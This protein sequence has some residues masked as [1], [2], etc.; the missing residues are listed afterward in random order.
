MK[1]LFV[2]LTI[3]V[4]LAGIFSICKPNHVSAYDSIFIY[5]AS[6]LCLRGTTCPQ[7]PVKK[8]WW[9]APAPLFYPAALWLSI[10]WAAI[11]YDNVD[12]RLVGVPLQYSVGDGWYKSDWVEHQGLYLCVMVQRLGHI[13]DCQYDYCPLMPTE[14][15]DLAIAVRD[16]VTKTDTL[17]QE[18]LYIT[19]YVLK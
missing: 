10:D 8:A 4:T 16:N 11:G 2:M 19:P 14:R 1:K 12:N 18:Y 15:L 13:P 17:L 3:V 7:P 9:I 5:E 6:T